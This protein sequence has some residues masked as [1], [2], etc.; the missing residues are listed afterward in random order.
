MKMV[1]ICNC[2]DACTGLRLVGVETYFVS[3]A[4]ELIVTLTN[5]P[6]QDIGVLAISED[7]VTNGENTLTDF[8]SNFLSGNPHILVAYW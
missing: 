6:A 3:N 4:Q 8:L 2:H 5:L 1:A 7:L